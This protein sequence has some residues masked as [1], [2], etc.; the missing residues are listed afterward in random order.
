MNTKL[1]SLHNSLF[2]RSIDDLFEGFWKATPQRGSAW[3]PAVDVVE[4][5]DAYHFHA[6]LPGF[7]PADIELEV[8]AEELTLSGERKAM[9]QEEKDNVHIIERRYGKF[10]R[11]FTFP[12]PVDT[13]SVQATAKDG[14][15][16]V[17]V[18]KSAAAQSRR[19]EIQ[20][21]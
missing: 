4:R 9:T 11:S 6:E 16:H 21:G 8:T 2:P 7:E 3:V 18:K 17:T 13:G 1:P 5:D 15:L 19:I 14:I 10:S 12:A 20:N